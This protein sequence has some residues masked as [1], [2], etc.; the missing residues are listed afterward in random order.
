MRYETI[1]SNSSSVTVDLLHT[2]F[3]LG[4]EIEDMAEAVARV[5]I[6]ARGGSDGGGRPRSG[7]GAARG[8]R[9]SVAAAD[10]GRSGWNR[11]GTNTLTGGFSRKE[12]EEAV[13]AK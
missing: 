3:G 12:E 11:G 6:W 5:S 13:R 7:G 2:S 9:R 1:F 10:L 4:T 8:R